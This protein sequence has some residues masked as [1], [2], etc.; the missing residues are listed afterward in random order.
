MIAL[1]ILP[2]NSPFT[3][4]PNLL[5]LFG[6]FIFW[7][8]FIIILIW[9]YDKLTKSNF[10]K[11]KSKII[12]KNTSWAKIFSNLFILIPLILIIFK[13]INFG[14]LFT[15]FD[16]FILISLVTLIL[17][18]N[19]TS[20]ANISSKFNLSKNFSLDNPI[21]Q[22]KDIILQSNSADANFIIAAKKTSTWTKIL[23]FILIDIVAVTP[24]VDIF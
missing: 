10:N 12:S 13:Y 15:G 18:L 23:A 24:L 14:D 3:S 4:P 17:Y 8:P 16:V 20:E 22:T 6:V 5:E 19:N 9:Y 11:N 2:I 7:L 1:S 21:Y